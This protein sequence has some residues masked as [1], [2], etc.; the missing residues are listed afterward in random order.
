MNKIIDINTSWLRWISNW[1]RANGDWRPSAVLHTVQRQIGTACLWTAWPFKVGLIV[2][3]ETSVTN[4]Q[5]KRRK[6]PGYVTAVRTWHKSDRWT[7]IILCHFHA[8][9]FTFCR[10]FL[11]C[12]FNCGLFSCIRTNNVPMMGQSCLFHCRSSGLQEMFV[13]WQPAG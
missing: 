4:Y 6:I 9:Q 3:A 5:S 1:R 12:L 8:K 2:S 13:L 11:T 10:H 7:V